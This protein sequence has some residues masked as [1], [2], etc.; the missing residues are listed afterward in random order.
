M[1]VCVILSVL[2]FQEIADVCVRG[3]V[4]GGV[5]PQHTL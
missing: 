3:L 2:T 4:D 5:G 1:C